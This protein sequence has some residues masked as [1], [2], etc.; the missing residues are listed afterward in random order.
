MRNAMNIYKRKDGRFEGRI[1][2]GYDNKGRLKYRYLYSRNLVELKEKMLSAY[3]ETGNS[4]SNT[5]GK[6]FR[7]LCCEWLASAKLRVKH[8]S[9]CCYEKL[10]NKHVIPYFEDI[11][12]GELGTLIINAFAEYKLKHGKINGKGGLC[13]KSVHD[14]LVVMRS[15]A[16]YAEREYGYRNPMRNISMPKSENKETLVFS[17]DE[18]GRLQNYLQSN[19]TESNLGTLLA[20]YSGLRIGELCALMWNDID[21]ENGVVRV[22]KALQR[23]SEERRAGNSGA[24]YRAAQTLGTDDVCAMASLTPQQQYEL[25]YSCGNEDINKMLEDYTEKTTVF[26]CIGFYEYIHQRAAEEARGCTLY[27]APG[28]VPKDVPEN[29]DVRNDPGL[30]EGFLLEEAGTVYD[31]SLRVREIS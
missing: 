24:A 14:I 6:T 3:V 27:V 17:K 29:I 11:G 9:Y 7:E 13:A 19:L 25:L 8:S 22:S 12:Y 21:F 23:V 15:V 10:I 5:C 28:V 31:Y 1:P 16:K 2:L 26:S 18:R 30:C 4:T 20:M